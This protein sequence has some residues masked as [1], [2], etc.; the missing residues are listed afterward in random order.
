MK[1]FYLKDK[2]LVT[3]GETLALIASTALTTLA[4]HN[5]VARRNVR[6]ILESK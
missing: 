1:T 6:N 2:P 3:L 4:V 5:V